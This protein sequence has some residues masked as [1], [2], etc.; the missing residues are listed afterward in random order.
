MLDLIPTELI[1]YAGESIPLMLT[2][3]KD[4]NGNALTS[5]EDYTVVIETRDGMKPCVAVAVDKSS[6]LTGD[7]GVLI[8]TN[9]AT[10]MWTVAETAA[11]PR[12]IVFYVKL[13]N[14]DG[15]AS[16]IA[17]G[18]ITVRKP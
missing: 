2:V 8:A 3:T 11:F 15:I 12:R 5:I 10:W 9:T 1:A 14:S 7:D 18:H 16:V 4:G 13:I 6:D 17:F